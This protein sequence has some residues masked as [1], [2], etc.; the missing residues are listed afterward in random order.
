[1]SYSGTKRSYGNSLKSYGGRTR[2]AKYTSRVGR[3]MIGR[4]SGPGRSG[5]SSNFFRLQRAYKNEMG[6]LDIAS[7]VYGLNTTGSVTLLN[8]V[9]QGAAV[10]QRVG[11]KIVMKGLQARGTMYGDNT[12]IYN[13]VAFMIVYDKRPTGA[14]PTITDILVSAGPQ[15]MNN[16]ANA[17]RFRIVKRVDEILIGNASTTGAVANALTEA[18]IKSCDWWLDLKG[19][20]VVYKA[21]GTGAIGDIEQG[22]LYLVT[23]GGQVA[24]TADATLDVSFRLR[25]LDV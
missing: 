18:S 5:F 1:M 22:A 2:R 19:L 16:D 25:F 7:A 12:A 24:G 11:K 10:T 13:D 4:N 21:A 8:A 3:P 15:S 17:G 6:Y 20:P 23:I 14:L 9:P